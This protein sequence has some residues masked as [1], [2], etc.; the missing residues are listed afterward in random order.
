MINDNK[1]EKN[2]SMYACGVGTKKLLLFYFYLFN[3][4]Y[5]S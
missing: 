5:F 3:L 1:L 4:I 2:Y